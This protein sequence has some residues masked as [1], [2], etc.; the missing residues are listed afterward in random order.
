MLKYLFLIKNKAQN[1]LLKFAK[2]SQS[3]QNVNKTEN[4][5]KLRTGN[6]LLSYLHIDLKQC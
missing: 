1:S 2:N 5:K 3:S 4:L 6:Y